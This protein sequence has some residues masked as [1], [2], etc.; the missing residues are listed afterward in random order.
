MC[1]ARRDRWLDD[2]IFLSSLQSALLELG[3][4]DTIPLPEA[5]EDPEVHQHVLAGDAVA[6]YAE[7]LADLAERKLIYVYRG[8]WDAS[9]PQTVPGSEARRILHEAHWY[10]WEDERL[11]YVN[12]ENVIA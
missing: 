5:F 2:S 10:R 8:R 6:Q 12:V 7:A 1:G 11:Y 3:L 4:E 9:E